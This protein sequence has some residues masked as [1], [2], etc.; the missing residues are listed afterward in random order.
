MYIEKVKI[1][2]FKCFEGWFEVDFNQGV[3]IIVGNNEAGKSTL[4]EAIGNL[5][6]FNRVHP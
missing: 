2:N 4:L 5:P 6:I 1:K 3:N